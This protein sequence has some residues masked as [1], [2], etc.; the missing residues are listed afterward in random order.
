MKRK[1]CIV[2]VLLALT[3]CACQAEE[4]EGAALEGVETV[5]EAAAL[6]KKLLED[7][8]LT[9]ADM[10][11]LSNDIYKVWDGALNELWQALK[12]SQDAGTF[13]QLLEEQRAWIAEKEAEVKRAG[14]NVGGGSMAPMVTSQ[15]VAKLTKERVYELAGYL[16]Y[17]GTGEESNEFTSQET[18]TTI[19]FIVEGMEEEVPATVFEGLNYTIAI[20]DDGWEMIARECWAADANGD[21]QFWV[22][23][24]AGE[25]VDAGVAS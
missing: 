6:E 4:Q 8:S 9:Q 23:D 18:K 5:I 16:G 19:T 24:Y 14:E 7:R 17:V 2:A 3:L 12:N 11:E 15:R 22:T 10:N 20:P 25:D 1:S 13:E 21:A